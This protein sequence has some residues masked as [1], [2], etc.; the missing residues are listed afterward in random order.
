M[1]KSISKDLIR[2]IMLMVVF[3][4]IN[5]VMGAILAERAG[6]SIKNL[7]AARMLDVSNAAA[8]LIDGDDLKA[9]TA[10]GTDTPEY[11]HIYDTLKVFQDN[12]DLKYIYSIKQVGER[13]FV[14]GIDPAE[15]NPGEFGSPVA[16][17]EA[18]YQASLGTPSV[19]DTPY[20]D[21][22]GSFYSAYTP[23]FDSSGNVAG[24]VAVDYSKD[25]YDAQMSQQMKITAVA[26]IVAVLVGS[27]II[28]L[29]LRRSRKNRQITDHLGKQ[30]SSTAEIYISMHE[31]NFVTDTFNEVRNKTEDATSIIGETRH[32]CQQVI[33]EDMARFSDE[34]TRES[35]LDFVDFSKLNSRLRDRN[36]ITSEFMT[37]DK[38]WRKARYI[39]SE[40]LPDGRVSSAL[41]LIEDIDA[42][43][44]DR[45]TAVDAVK[46]MNEQ[47][48]SLANIYVSMFDVDLT[49]D[50]V[51]EIKTNVSNI[52]DI[53]TQYND[54][55]QDAALA[56]V[57]R[58]SSR[59]TR[60]AMR[61]FMDFGT[62][63]SRL[64]ESNTI[65]EEFLN[66]D[67]IWC[68][69]RFVIS[70]YGEGGKIEHVLWLVESIDE[71]KR[72]RDE[73]SRAAESLNTQMASI[74]KIFMTVFD[75]DL[76]ADSFVVIK[77]E[78]IIVNNQI[79]DHRSN[80][81]ALMRES[82][83][84]LTDASSL[85]DVLT[86]VDLST[87]D[88]RLRDTESVALEMLTKTGKWVR[89]RFMASQRTDKG[90]LSH[91]LWLAEDISAEK[92]E[93]DKLIDMSER[94]LAA[95]E[96]KSS[97]LSNM[98]H[99]IRTPI[100]AVLGMNEMILRECEDKSILTYSESIRTAGTT[101]LGLIND[102]LDFSKIEAGKMEIIPVDYDLSSVINDLVNMIQ[103]KADAKD[104]ILELEISHTVPKILHG[105][106]VRIKQVITN[107]LT[108]AVKYTEKGTVTFWME[109]A[110]IPDEPD[111]V[112]LKVM[113]KDTG[114][115]IR[116][117]DMRK[118][119][120]KFDRIDEE[121]NRNVEGTGLGMSIT[122]RLLEM[123]GSSLVAE[124]IYGLGSKFYFELK[125][126]VVRWEELGDY[127]AAY[128]DSLGQREKY[129]EKFR[130][131]DAHLL[132]VDD[133]PMNLVVFRSLLKQTAVKIDTANSG[134]E[135]L[136]LSLEKKYDMIFLDHM[137]PE[138]DG[139]ETLHEMRADKND[140]N[141]E[142]PVICLT[143]NAISGAKEKY[144]AEGF[145]DYLSKPIDA[146]KL[147]EMLIRYLPEDKVITAPN[148]EEALE[149]ESEEKPLP[150]WLLSCK[151]LDLGE[152]VKNS[153]GAEEYLS[154]LS[155]F[156]A[157][158]SEKADEIENFYKEGDIRNYTIKVHALKSSARIIGAKELSDMAK[159]LEDAGNANDMAYIDERTGELLKLYRSYD[160]ILAPINEVSE[161]L[162][163]IPQETLKD[164]YEAIGEFITMM[165]LD[166]V[167]MTLDSVKEYRLS[168]KDSECFRKIRVKASQLDWDGIKEI[169][170]KKDS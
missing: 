37:P 146:E 89:V 57:D 81:K 154:V 162:P 152:G 51:R 130:A 107:I 72:K 123:M 12:I 2:Y 135:G 45:D 145:Q 47:M 8:A 54:H 86:F 11:R 150:D 141:K 117:E 122:K 158:V 148:D 74:S 73:I 136:S 33:R 127:A 88:R 76:F 109:Y 79:K 97:F 102:I 17:T 87:L 16:Y 147:E 66:N 77:S 167:L 91:V 52:A 9:L 55:A 153:G 99:E 128:R 50:R 40:R 13:E 139:I 75:I 103:T 1:K 85:D 110:K 83:T 41:Y 131:P 129:H 38:K 60:R 49:N 118:L 114:I 156:Q 3:V 32:H 56:M 65:T 68:R 142:T 23:V 70:K 137:M 140:Q 63:D 113:V 26:I 161:D 95:S 21:E 138:K 22:W 120:S 170:E 133:T 58:T 28:I 160:E 100:N 6:N 71:E 46:I 132:V 69:A 14:F 7:I 155:S 168:P 15:D 151:D 134:A 67:N 96:A 126:K 82:M 159:S 53:D 101:L 115:G 106:E 80:A 164:A 5:T 124:S 116:K 20:E 10:D 143:A 59:M 30:L 119:F 93:R 64:H 34:S 31:I 92:A 78:N 166:L 27:L 29:M 62:L 105:D 163:E 169:L 18:L 144:L 94:A 104:L 44:R 61:E 111:Y 19:D 157:V 84:Q 98:S 4:A 36:T 48:S 24:I 125:Q 149:A 108:N 112:M 165:D 39:V 90:R 42:E 25:W 121:R 43:K 35:L